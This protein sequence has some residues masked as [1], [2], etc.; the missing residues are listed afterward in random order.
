[1]SEQDVTF[2]HGTTSSYV[3]RKCRCDE[4]RAGWAEYNADRRIAAM[5][6]PAGIEEIGD[7]LADQRMHAVLHI[8]HGHQR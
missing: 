8:Q 6:E 2:E 4:C 5:R 1:M 3:Y 7:Q